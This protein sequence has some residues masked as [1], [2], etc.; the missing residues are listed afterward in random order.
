MRA[1]TGGQ[2]PSVDCQGEILPVGFR[3]GGRS[4]CLLAAVATLPPHAAM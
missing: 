1:R 3:G 4:A 2:Q